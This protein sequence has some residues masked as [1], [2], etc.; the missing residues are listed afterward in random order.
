MI[1]PYMRTASGESE[2]RAYIT[3][4]TLKLDS[5]DSCIVGDLSTDGLANVVS[6][7]AQ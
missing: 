4:L 6:R 1:P 5:Y 2:P 3:L 7:V